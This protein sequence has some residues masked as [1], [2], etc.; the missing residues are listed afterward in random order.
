MRAGTIAAATVLAIQALLAAPGQAAPSFTRVGGD[1]AAGAGAIAVATGD[2][3]KD[4]KLDV[5]VANNDSDDVSVLM[6]NGDGS[7]ADTPENFPV[8]SP[9]PAAVAVGDF[10]GDGKLDIVTANEIGDQVSVLLGAGNGSFAAAVTSPT[11]QSPESI[12]V[13]DF[14][15]DGKL[16]VATA[17]NFADTVTILHGVGDGTFTILQTVPVGAEPV[18]LAMGDLNGD[19]IVDLIVT[20]S[21]GGPQ[22]AGSITVLK[23]LGEG[24]FDAQAEIQ[25]LTFN[26]PVAVTS[27]ELNGDDKLDIV[28]ANEEGDAV[29]VLRG[30]GDLTFETDTMVAVGS[31]PEAVVAADFDGDGKADIAT[32]SNFDDNVS[33]LQ[34]MGD[35]TLMAA[36][37]FPVGAAPFGLTTA[38]LN[39]DSKPDM[40]TAN[41]E[42][43]SVSVLLN[44]SGPVT[45]GCTGDCNA[46]HD[47]TVD[48]LIT[49]VNIALDTAQVSA[50]P[51]GDKDG[52]GTITIVEIIAAV[53]NALNGCP[54]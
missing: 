6:G 18:G 11:G 32:S 22:A 50:C 23:G 47:V 16:D 35:G 24:F 8:N 17:D 45:A 42:D 34:G 25:G 40:A 29:S 27:V 53:N 20:N 10:N 12:R 43:G 19:H 51:A 41:L 33:V 5:V 30:K 21:S 37:A 7:L 9:A 14:D 39:N 13:G 49:M 36:V 1:F 26:V 44:T 3:N 15:G 28:V 54:A 38:D 4:G 46:G 48:E 2:F 31:F 52:D